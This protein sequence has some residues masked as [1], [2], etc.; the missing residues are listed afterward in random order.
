MHTNTRIDI[1]DNKNNYFHNKPYQ[2]PY[3]YVNSIP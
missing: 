1:H 2:T 3:I